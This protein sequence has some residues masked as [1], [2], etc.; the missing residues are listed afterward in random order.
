MGRMTSTIC[1][2]IKAKV[3]LL[4]ASPLYNGSFPYPDFKNTNWE[5]PGY[6]QELISHTY[7]ASK[8]NRAYAAANEAINWAENQGDRAIYRG[9]EYVNANINLDDVYIPGGE[10]GRAH[11]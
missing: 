1:K 4:A 6:G 9:N 10:I 3:L 11:V 8:W 7:D 5:T 2:A